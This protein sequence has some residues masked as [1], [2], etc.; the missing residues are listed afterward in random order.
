MSRHDTY[1]FE[2][3]N[4]V[5]RDRLAAHATLWDPFT[6]RQ[7][8]HTGI[9]DGWCCLEIGAGTG[10]VASWM[11]DRVGPNGH[12]VATDIETRWLS[13]ATN[14]E[15][16][17][18]N[19]VEDPV[20]RSGYDLIHA[21]LVL[22]HLPQR[23]A[24]LA[25]LIDGLR[26]GGWLVVEDYDLRTI[27]VTVPPSDAWSA[28]GAAV[29]SVLETAGVDPHLGTSLH[30]ALRSR[31]L[32]EVVAEGVV[33]CV[34]TEQLGASFLPVIEQLGERIIATGN[35]TTDQLDEV[36]SDMRWGRH[37]GVAYTP[38]LIAARGRRPPGFRVAEMG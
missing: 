5:E 24:V 6:F 4:T 1:V 22:E 27:S 23:R 33:H 26:P 25:K 34:P 15:V 21:R 37:N 19:I 18:H 2:T 38:V 11:V 12:V 3:A 35:V 14:L 9:S 29:I 20:D 32:V 30:T 17:H 31:G 36:V 28:M 7:L 10:S 8:D 13:T 16:R